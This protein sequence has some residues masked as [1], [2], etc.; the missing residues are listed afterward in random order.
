MELSFNVDI[1]SR[2]Y[3]SPLYFGFYEHIIPNIGNMFIAFVFN[4]ILYCKISKSMENYAHNIYPSFFFPFC[5]LPSLPTVRQ[6]VG[7]LLPR[8]YIYKK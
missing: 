8:Q 3:T 1:Y 2:E 4:L 7:G 6:A 5:S